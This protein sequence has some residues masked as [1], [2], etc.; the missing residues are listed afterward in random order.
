V[1]RKTRVSWTRK[2]VRENVSA[3]RWRSLAIWLT[4]PENSVVWAN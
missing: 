4:S 3:N 1:S 2:K